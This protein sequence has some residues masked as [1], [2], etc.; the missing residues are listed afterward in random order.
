MIHRDISAS[1]V[2]VTVLDGEPMVKI[3]DFGIAVLK[4][5]PAG[6]GNRG[7]QCGRR[8]GT[9]GKWA[10]MSPEHLN[11]PSSALTP[12]ADVYSL[13][14]LLFELITGSTPYAASTVKEARTQQSKIQESGRQAI[15]PSTKIQELSA[16]LNVKDAKAASTGS[17]PATG[18]K[19]GLR[20][21][22]R[23][24]DKG[25]RPG[26]EMAYASVGE[27]AED[28]RA[29]LTN[30]RSPAC[31]AE[32]DYAIPKVLASELGGRAATAAVVFLAISVFNFYQSAM[33]QRQLNAQLLKAKKKSEERRIQS[34]Q[35]YSKLHSAHAK[36]YAAQIRSL[37]DISPQRR[38]RSVGGQVL[39][40]TVDSREDTAAMRDWE[41]WA[42]AGAGR[43]GGTSARPEPRGF[44]RR[45]RRR[46]L[47]LRGGGRTTSFGFGPLAT[48]VFNRG[49]SPPGKN[50]GDRGRGGKML[51]LR[52]RRHV[53]P[54]EC[55]ITAAMTLGARST[56]RISTVRPSNSPTAATGFASIDQT[57]RSCRCSRRSRTRSPPRSSNSWN[58]RRGL[59]TSNYR[60]ATG[61]WYVAGAPRTPTIPKLPSI[62]CGSGRLDAESRRGDLPRSPEWYFDDLPFLTPEAFKHVG[63]CF[64]GSIRSCDLIHRRRFA[65]GSAVTVEEKTVEILPGEGFWLVAVPSPD[66]KKAATGG[67]AGDRTIR[68]WN[69]ETGEFE[70]RISGAP[71]DLGTM[72]GHDDA[73][74]KLAF[75]A[76]SQSLISASLDGTVRQWR[77]GRS[78]LCPTVD[79]RRPRQQ[80]PGIV[81]GTFHR[82]GPAVE[83]TR[84]LRDLSMDAHL[85]RCNRR[86]S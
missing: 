20:R 39:F 74:T 4:K 29:I 71:D 45:A 85:E 64:C 11:N 13:G 48:E 3:I 63:R 84:N 35:N 9:F 65:C 59:A 43:D 47:D 70:G 58:C 38:T 40:G 37:L 49:E 33:E 61:V 67:A 72:L 82:S 86:G 50:T 28:L 10:Y 18:A 12:Q 5:A 7:V 54:L 41:W 30:C 77:A 22:R 21:P 26:T 27:L 53:G 51:D 46:R 44:R 25:N 62:G 78:V 69:A 76:N 73:V 83:T 19:G 6:W 15:A 60:A 68:L 1:N 66:G 31:P 57:R 80:D 52:C 75:T 17:P 2:M 8:L 36:S 79:A 34:D 56:G 32:S 23:H 81:M 14:V 16:T 55:E 24:R 42:L